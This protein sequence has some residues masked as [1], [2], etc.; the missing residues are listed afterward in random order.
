MFNWIKKQF[1]RRSLEN[2]STPFSSVV[3]QPNTIAGQAIDEETCFSHL[4]VYAAINRISTDMALLDAR[5]EEHRKASKSLAV[6]HPQ[7]H[8][9]TV[10]PDGVTSASRWR[11]TTIVHLCTYGN[12]YDEIVFDPNTWQP[13]GWHKLDPRR[14]TPKLNKAGKLVYEYRYENGRTD[15]LP[16]FKVLHFA[17]MS[18]DGIVGYSPIRCARETLALGKAADIFGASFFGQ[19]ARPSGMLT[20]TKELSDP[21]FRRLRQDVENLYTG[22][23]NAG[24][25]FVGEEGMGF[26]PI[27]IPPDDAQFL[28]TR[29]MSIED[30]ARLFGIPAHKIGGAAASGS[31]EEQNIDYQQSTLLGYCNIIED[32]LELKILNN[33]HELGV[34]KVSHDFQKLLRANAAARAA[35][36][37]TAIQWGWATRNRVAEDEGYEPYKGGELPLLPLNMMMIGPDGTASHTTDTKGQRI[38]S[39]AT[40]ATRW[41]SIVPASGQ[42]FVASEQIRNSTSHKVVMRYYDGL[43]PRDRIK[44]GSRIFNI[45]S[46][47]DENSLKTR[48]TLLV[49]EVI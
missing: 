27:T 34:F 31:V 47:L 38:T 4:P 24:R 8:R 9:F 18:G 23:Q 49:T 33:P 29:K 48:H 46:V 11:Q 1:S 21:A 22:S 14:M 42:Y 5:L 36:N 19:A 10:S 41:A 40:I 20:V 12:S 2:P 25:V 13:I 32:E 16:A 43:S 6:D 15:T 35:Y 26:T 17:M 45:L 30:V 39:Y 37:A 44:Y 28:E 3:G 7:Y